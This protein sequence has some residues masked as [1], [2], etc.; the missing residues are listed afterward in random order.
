MPVRRKDAR[1]KMSG[2]E[3]V[4]KLRFSSSLS[5]ETTLSNDTELLM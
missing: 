1:S 4:E 3:T 2:R 5:L